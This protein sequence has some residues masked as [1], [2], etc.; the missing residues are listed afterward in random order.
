VLLA[1]VAAAHALVV[2]VQRRARDLALLRTLGFVGGQ[3]RGTIAWQASTVA[4]VGLLLGVPAGLILGRV[5]WGV[6]A[7]D[8]GVDTDWSVPVL[9]VLLVLPASVVVANLIATV[10]ARTAARARLG[11]ALRTE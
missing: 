8:L 6:A 1:G 9:A 3:I 10:P 11:D 7:G 4:V 2:S 5:V